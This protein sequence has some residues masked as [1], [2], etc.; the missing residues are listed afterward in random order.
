M[1]AVENPQA[2]TAERLLKS[3]SKNSYDP[4][5]DIDWDAEV[6]DELAYLPMERVSLYGTAL[7]DEMS[8]GQRRELSKLELMSVAGTG[9]WFEII[10]IQM[11]AATPTT[12]IRR[13]RT[14]STR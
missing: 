12:R 13:R 8:E 7:W 2:R 9:L 11:L 3:S 5:L 10:L 14:P 1:T 6:P 4:L